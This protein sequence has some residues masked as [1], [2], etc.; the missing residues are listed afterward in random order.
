ML[1]Q[2]KLPG[3]LRAEAIGHSV[4]LRNRTYTSSLPESKTPYEMATGIKPNLTGLLEWGSKVWVK[5]LNAGK[6]RPQALEARFVG[7]NDESKG[8]RIYWP[9]HRKVSIEH[10]VYPVNP[11]H[12]HLKP[13]RLRGR[14]SLNPKQSIRT[15]RNQLLPLQ[16]SLSLPK[17]SKILNQMFRTHPKSLLHQKFHS[18]MNRTFRM[19]TRLPHHIVEPA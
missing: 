7:I 11:Q 13:S 8:Y 5:K 12:L 16:K 19:I 18:H 10:D 17:M 4:W 2:A 9:S 6:L 1:I 3:F 15:I 14:M